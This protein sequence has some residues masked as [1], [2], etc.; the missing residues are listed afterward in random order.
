MHSKRKLIYSEDLLIIIVDSQKRLLDIENNTGN[1]III[2]QGLFLM[3]YSTFEDALRKIIRIVLLCFPEKLDVKSCTITKQQVCEIADKGHSII[4]DNEIYQ[5]FRNGVKEQIAYILKIISNKRERDFDENLKAIINN[6][7]EISLIRNALIHNAGKS[8]EQMLINNDFF[9]VVNRDSIHIEKKHIENIFNE[10]RAL[11][12]YISNEIANTYQEYNK[13]PRVERVRLAWERC[14]KSPIMKFHDYWDIDF[15]KDVLK[16]VLYPE[17]EAGIS[18]SESVLLS[19]W[20][21]QYDNKIPT[22]EFL[23]CSVNHEKIALVYKELYDIEFFYMK[24]KAE[25]KT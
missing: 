15:D 9:N 19:I 20:R 1:N 3:A 5:L 8:T 16:G 7:R 23:L 2:N 12:S 17:I 14:F 13:L 22:Q 21:H 25:A 11:V 18:S 4:I 24:Q 10:L 6:C